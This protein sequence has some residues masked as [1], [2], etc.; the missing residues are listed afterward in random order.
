MIT[1]LREKF[2]NEMMAAIREE[3]NKEK[4]RTLKLSIATDHGFK[5]ELM[6]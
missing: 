5:N 4:G 2:R 3:E 1:L 6:K